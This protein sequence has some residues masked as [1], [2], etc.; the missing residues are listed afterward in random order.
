MSQ[1]NHYPPA[2]ERWMITVTI[3][4][5][6]VIEVLDMTIVNVALPKMM[7][8]LGTTSDK[9]TWVLTSYI[10]TSAI[11]MLLT[12]FLDSKFGRRHLLLVSIIGFMLAS[13][14]CGTATS[15][16]EI[17]FFRA[18]QGIFGASLVPLSQTVL[19]ATFPPNE[20]GKA[21]AIWGIGIMVAPVLGPTLGGYITEHSS[22][23]WIFYINV[24][25]CT[26]SFFMALRFIKNNVRTAIKIDWLG[27]ILMGVGVGAFQIFLDEGNT[28]D[29]FESKIIVALA[30]ITLF[31][32]S[33]F[34]IRGINNPDNIIDFKLFKDR[35]FTFSTIMMAIFT[36]GVL[37]IIA[38]QPILL[39][40]YFGYPTELTGLVM[41]PRG[42]AA[43]IG[44]VF[45]GVLINRVDPRK[46]MFLALAA[47]IIGSYM[48]SGYNLDTDISH[49]I[50]SGVVQGLGM[51]MFMVPLATLSLA[52]LAEKHSAA[53]AGLFSF[54]RNLG[55]SVGISILSTIIARE[56]QINWNRLGSNI[57]PFNTNLQLWLNH[58]GW[59]LHDPIALSTLQNTL[60]AQSGMIAYVDSFWIIS[61]SL[62]LLIPFIFFIK[63]PALKAG[64]G[65]IH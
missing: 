62:V 29:W 58:Q 4:L 49:W 30:A 21:M 19:R 37:G 45:T 46:L 42:I 59:Q 24:P 43:A 12:G 41:A 20:Q 52:S 13:V 9:I 38:I 53:G 36:M 2:F 48:M 5:V 17:V 15:L 10:V 39:E 8:A 28:L 33:A 56:T 27:A 7:G 63:K 22:W 57:N 26:L 11:F 35:N 60:A 25:V 34:I 16:D 40:N 31:S 18:L 47:S 51:G 50:W 6:A 55:S 61:L 64:V 1:L 23:R 54:G 14:L 44:M 3:M 32:L 65:M